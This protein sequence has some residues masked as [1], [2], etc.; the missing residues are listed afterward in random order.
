MESMLPYGLV[1]GEHQLYVRTYANGT[2][3]D[4]QQVAT[5]PRVDLPA[6]MV[7]SK[8][9]GLTVTTL[10]GRPHLTWP[11]DDNALY[12]WVYVGDQGTYAM[13]HYQWYKKTTAICCGGSCSLN[14]DFYPEN[15]SYAIFMQAWG[16]GGVNGG[17]I[18]LWSDELQFSAN[19]PRPSAVKSLNASVLS[20][21]L[22]GSVQLT[23]MG[24]DHANRYN[25]WVGIV[26]PGTNIQT[27]H[28]T[29]ASAIDLGCG[30]IGQTCTYMPPM[31]FSPGNYSWYVQAE[32]PGGTAI[33]GVI[34]GWVKGPVF[35]P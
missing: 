16:P 2:L 34:D 18:K 21:V 14:V 32:G 31:I 13:R 28:H 23:W 20:G 17:D 35:T 9:M 7:I 8:A 4:Y 5:L 1:N 15:G 29:A 22:N 3:S 27:M 19:L 33:G 6:P 30:T 24:V 11:Q 10:Q 25:I 26:T 12:Y